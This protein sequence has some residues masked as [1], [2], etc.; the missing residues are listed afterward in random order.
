MLWLAFTLNGQDPFHIFYGTN[1]GL[2]SSEVYDIHVDD[3]NMVWLTT[4]RGVCRYNGYEFT[5]Y[6]TQEGLTYNTNFSIVPD[7]D[8][9]FWFNAFDGTLS[10][11]EKGHFSPH[12]LNDSLKNLYGGNYISKMIFDEKN[13]LHFIFNE[14]TPSNLTKRSHYY[15]I[16]TLSQSIVPVNIN[17]TDAMLSYDGE[18]EVIVQPIGG[19]AFI[20]IKNQQVFADQNLKISNQ[21]TLF[22]FFDHTVKNQFRK[23]AIYEIND[24]S[25]NKLYETPNAIDGLYKDNLGHIWLC[26]SQGLELFKNGVFDHSPKHFFQD[27]FITD[28]FQDKEN[29]YWIST[30]QH[31]IIFVPS[32]EFNGLVE[33]E[34]PSIHDKIL[35]IEQFGSY[36]VYGTSDGWI[37]SIDKQLNIIPLV[38]DRDRYISHIY[39]KGDIGYTSYFNKITNKN[40]QLDITA[41]PSKRTSYRLVKELQNGDLFCA[42]SNY[43]IY[44]NGEEIYQSFKGPQPFNRSFTC[45]EEDEQGNIL[46]GT[47][48]GLISINKNQY[49]E[50]TDLSVAH[51]LLKTRISEIRKMGQ[52]GYWIATIGN[53]LLFKKKDSVFQFTDSIG[54][55][56]NLIN[57][58]Y[59]ENDSILWVGSNEGLDKILFDLETNRISIKNI[60][61][62]NTVNGLPSN[63]I[64]D[65]EHWNDLIWVVTD[66]GIYYFSPEL[67]LDNVNTPGIF[68][69]NTK[70]NNEDVKLS[71]QLNLKHDQNDISFEYTGISYRKPKDF[72]FYRYQ[73]W[74]EG[75]PKEWRYTNAR[76]A[77]FFN[78]S[79][80]DYLFKVEAQNN[81]GLWS[82]NPATMTIKIQPHITQTLWFKI[83]S[84]TTL[85]AIIYLVWQRIHKNRKWKKKQERM[86]QEANFRVKN[87]ELSVLRKQMN[88]HFIFNSLNA[89]QNFIFGNDI[90]RANHFLSSF[91]K[92]MRDSIQMSKLDYI[93]LQKEITFLKAYLELEQMRFPDRFEFEFIVEEEIPINQTLISPLLLQPIL[94]NAIKHGFKGILYKGKLEINIQKQRDEE[95]LLNITISDNGNGINKTTSSS[96]TN[97]SSMSLEII[98]ERI[99]IINY[100][101]GQDKAVF[102]IA[103]ESEKKGTIITLILPF[104]SIIYDQISNH[105]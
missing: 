23:Y 30:L 62:Y 59:L 61:T 20:Y 39:I 35:S 21:K 55:A 7:S 65:I 33:G 57:T 74:K 9:R 95:G 48:S 1:D 97:H 54:I 93:T 72:P 73:F 75:Q 58:I 64:R 105:R 51:N 94:E 45:V 90:S 99:N 56:S 49:D 19:E 27:Y 46:A 31:G 38:K 42:R 52:D 77:Y 43:A 10:C 89:I 8:G 68:L 66:N 24:H 69:T 16:D 40:T 17:T 6:T 96:S 36:L 104:K 92:L 100:Q 76:N 14:N 83:I 91:S 4:D 63:V 37:K 11:Y 28:I 15:S 29:N 47:L 12:P 18:L 3:N 41:T 80:G 84:T 60:W 5:T 102:L 53:G 103:P 2:P 87:A 78:L 88:P 22:L 26:T 25:I 82:E 71:R 13:N 98:R 79:P 70:V 50:V 67:S 86:V 32:F 34:D 101:L 44:R 85:L 81:E